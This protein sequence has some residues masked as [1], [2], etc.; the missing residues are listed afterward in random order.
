MASPRTTMEARLEDM[1]RGLTAIERRQEEQG[2]AMELIA[3]QLG[4]LL[5]DRRASP[6][7][8]DPPQRRNL[9]REFTPEPARTP[10]LERHRELPRRD[11]RRQE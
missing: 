11:P 8:E 9:E 7:Q 4:Q 2:K 10:P 3:Q 6:Q 5:R 1:E